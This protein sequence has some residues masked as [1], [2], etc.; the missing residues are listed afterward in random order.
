MGYCCTK[1]S[2]HS[3]GLYRPGGMAQVENLAS[4]EEAFR[5]DDITGQTTLLEGDDFI[6]STRA[7]MEVLSTV[8]FR[9]N[10]LF[11]TLLLD[12]R[13][14]ELEQLLQDT[15][16]F[17]MGV[18]LYAQHGLIGLGQEKKV[19]VWL[20][21]QGL[22]WKL[23]LRME[24]MD[25]A[26]LLAYQLA[27]NWNGS[28]TLCMAVDDPETSQR[29]EEYL[30][31]L[32]TVARLPAKTQVKI[33]ENGFSEALSQAPHADL[34]IFGLQRH[35]PDLTFVSKTTEAIKGSCIFVRD[36]GDESAL[37]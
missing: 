23:G 7:A 11:L 10:I 2:I 29:A 25:L 27:C 22:Q 3:L 8:V 32:M 24:N 13:P 15:S 14:A 16:E 26:L 30:K 1:G 21:E 6:N 20:R 19:T 34:T 36:S 35:N 17:H 9:P 33:Y 31:E 18:I 4:L 5:E 12:E 37:A 28:I